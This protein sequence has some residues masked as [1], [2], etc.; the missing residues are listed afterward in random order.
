[1]NTSI[2]SYLDGLN[3]RQRIAVETLNGPV[4]VLAGAG[5]GKT[6]VVTCRIAN[7][8]ATGVPAQDILAITFTKKAA[9]EMKLRTQTILSG[10]SRSPTICTFHS[11]GYRMLCQQQIRVDDKGKLRILSPNKQRKLVAG[12]LNDVDCEHR[13]NVHEAIRF[14]SC[15]KNETV[16]DV[17]KK[18]DADLLRHEV[19]KEYQ[20]RLLEHQVVDFDDLLLIPRQ[21]LTESE[22][23]RN[24]YQTRWQHILVDEYQDTNRVQH[25]LMKLLV[26]PQRNICVVG[27]DDQSIYGF[28]GASSERIL[29]FHK[30]FPG[31]R[32]V[33]LDQSYRSHTEIVDV[34]NNVIRFSSNRHEKMLRSMRG[35][36]GKVVV[37]TAKNAEHESIAIADKIECQKLA[38]NHCWSDIAVLYRVHADGD[39]LRETLTD[40]NIPHQ[41]QISNLNSADAVTI[42]TLHRS[43]GLEFPI[44]FVPAIEEDTLPHFHAVRSGLSGI[45]EERRLFYVGVTRAQRELLLSSSLERRGKPRQTSR[46][47]SE[48]TSL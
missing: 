33:T 25:D 11:L 12:V 35:N 31:T 36:G 27:D 1:M 41:S 6:R 29:R 42:M 18:D 13:F 46:F 9:E 10:N 15:I 22:H 44:V 43:K 8:V 38:G 32:H 45:D 5:T 14:I 28:R 21:L 20:K 7:L 48:L 37:T 26:G 34:A 47:L 19:L 39:N 17:G 4:L 16:S 30:E 40:R 24:Y 23:L 3:A 2:A